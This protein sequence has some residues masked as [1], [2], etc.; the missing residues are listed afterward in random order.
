LVILLDTPKVASYKIYTAHI[1]T[2][3]RTVHI[4]NASFDE[5]K[6]AADTVITVFINAVCSANSERKTHSD[7]EASNEEP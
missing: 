2:L 5:P 3:Q 7:N 1:T 4:I 6:V